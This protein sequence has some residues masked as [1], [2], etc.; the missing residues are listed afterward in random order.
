MGVRLRL[1]YGSDVLYALTGMCGAMRA[2]WPSLPRSSSILRPRPA[3]LP[4]P[5]C[6]TARR[7]SRPSQP[8]PSGP[9]LIQMHACLVPPWHRQRLST[10]SALSRRRV[11]AWMEYWALLA[12][13]N[14]LIGTRY[15]HYCSTHVGLSV[16]RHWLRGSMA[17][18]I[19]K[20]VRTRRTVWYVRHTGVCDENRASS[21][22]ARYMGSH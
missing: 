1:E 18:A 21:P 8:S 4:L 17:D 11:D 12:R 9:S 14:R 10:V 3:A 7:A 20:L 16:A 6:L 5:E 2:K 13:F 22:F 15:R 19:A